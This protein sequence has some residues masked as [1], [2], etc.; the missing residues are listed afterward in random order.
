MVSSAPHS[1]NAPTPATGEQ[2]ADLKTYT[3]AKQVVARKIRSLEHFFYTH[4]SEKQADQCRE[5]MVK[6]AE[7]R[8]TLAVVGQFKRGKSS[9]M[10]AIV[11]QELLPTG[12]LPVTSVITSLRFGTH[13]RLLI[14][15][16][17]SRFLYDALP[18]ELSSY[19]TQEGNPGNQKQINAVYVELPLPFLR[20][21]VEFVDTPGVGSSIDANTATTMSFLPRCDAAV[22]VTSVDS[23]MTA[24][25]T[26]FLGDIHQHAEKL[27]FVVNKIDLLEDREREEVLEYISRIIQQNMG[28]TNPKIFPVSSRLGLK[29]RMA[30]DSEGYAQSGLAALE[31]ALAGFLSS[32]RSETLLIALLN[33]SL[34]LTGQQPELAEIEK[35]ITILRDAIAR[36]QADD[37]VLGEAVAVE[38]PASTAE[39]AP[40]QVSPQMTDNAKLLAAMATSGCPVCNYLAETAFN[41]FARWQY[42]LSSNEQTQRLFADEL[43]FCP[44]HTWQLADLSSIL[45]LS[46]SYPRLL[47]RLAHE[48]SNLTASAHNVLDSLN[49]LRENS[50]TCRVCALLQASEQQ[51]IARMATL[52]ADPAAQQAYAAAQGTCLRHLDMLLSATTNSDLQK[53][54]LTEAARHF[55]QWAEDMQSYA[56]KRDA[57]RRELQNR[58]EENAHLFALIHLAGHRSL[59]LPRAGDQL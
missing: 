57:L 49:K 1:N 32:E 18:S 59:C 35:Q 22:F 16:P 15:R 9:L 2:W 25:E 14:S 20:R 11:G 48:F 41:F 19:V 28:V 29:S 17:E 6:L 23:P 12:V 56:I 58:N 4:K 53:F 46:T 43:G 24:V 30:G 33:K 52:L 51:Y 36:H 44:L 42:D 26:A 31:E 55:E 50:K 7:D 8:F 39:I 40:I 38:P 37:A 45:G 3:K 5:L 13:E 34:R 47:E 21:G 54:L 27:F 10:N